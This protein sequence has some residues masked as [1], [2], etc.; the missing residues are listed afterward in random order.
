[1]SDA[2]APAVACRGVR[3]EYGRTIALRSVD[4]DVPFGSL[5]LLIGPNGA[6][7]STLLRICA[8]LTRP[9]SGRVAIDG[10]DAGLAAARARVG[11]LAHA[12]LLYASL[13]PIENLLFAGRLYGVPDAATRGA[14][15]LD[16]A[17]VGRRARDAISRLSRGTQQRVALCRAFLHEPRVLLFDEPF[18]GLDPDGVRLFSRWIREHVE[19]GGAALL[20]THDLDAGLAV[21]DAVAVLAAGRLGGTRA[22]AG[23]DGESIRA[24]YDGVARAAAAPASPAA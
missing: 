20:S 4:L 9:T 11:F 1:V 21:A 23:L 3:K 5:A 18:T 12:T 15:L 8:G 2:A 24:L 22:A 17:G 6:G 7:K 13:T 16:A 10:D 19:R 14:R